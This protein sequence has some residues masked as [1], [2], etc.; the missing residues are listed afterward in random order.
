MAG[1]VSAD[2]GRTLGRTIKGTHPFTVRGVE[3][4]SAGS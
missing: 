3:S 2:T 1:T 4:P